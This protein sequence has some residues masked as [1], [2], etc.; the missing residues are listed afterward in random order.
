M[1]TNTEKSDQAA[2]RERRK[3]EQER[4]RAAYVADLADR[5]IW[6]K[7][8]GNETFL[9]RPES[10]Y[11]SRCAHK[12]TAQALYAWLVE[13]GYLYQDGTVTERAYREVVAE[14]PDLATLVRRGETSYYYEHDARPG[15]LMYQDDD[16]RLTLAERK[17]IA[18]H[19]DQ[20]TFLRWNV[21]TGETLPQTWGHLGWGEAP[22]S[23]LRLLVTNA[24]YAAA[25]REAHL[26]ALMREERPR[27]VAAAMAAAAGVATEDRQSLAHALHVSQMPSDTIFQRT[28][29]E[30]W[31][32]RVAEQIDELSA[33]HEEIG[34]RITLLTM[35]DATINAAEGGWPAFVERYERDLRAVLEQRL[36]APTSPEAS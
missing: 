13:R 11:L 31:P 17:W 4:L 27:H 32:A 26:D 6:A 21:H 28:P 18:E 23:S 5:W 10:Y 1:T 7:G 36:D 20:Y 15:V 9:S 25:Q 30:A 35:A 34:R 33:R 16:E 3:A 12:R 22:S 24:S 2:E 29:P 8:F 14:E 19:P